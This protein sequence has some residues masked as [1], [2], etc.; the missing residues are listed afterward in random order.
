[1][2]RTFT[3]KNSKISL[4]EL[5]NFTVYPDRFTPNRDG[6]DD[7]VTIS[8]NLTRKADVL[9]YLMGADGK[10]YPVAERPDNAV[11]PGEPGVHTYDYEG[12]V[13]LGAMPPPDGTYRVIAEATDEAGNRVSK[14]AALT[15][16]DG[17]VPRAE[18]VGATA[19]LAP[20]SVPLG[21]TLTVTATVGNIGTVPIRTK[22]PWS[23]SSYTS[24]ENFNTAG[25]YEEPGVFRL[26]VDYE[27]NSA[28]R[29]YPYRWGLGREGDLQLI[30]GQR[31]LMPNQRIVVVGYIRIVEKTPTVNPFF[32]VGLLHEQVRLVNDRIQPTRITIGF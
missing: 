17:G 2:T 5:Q 14:S 4:P 7:R 10:K 29:A 13:D 11:K 26:G 27:G 20:T 6:I 24:L 30:G 31:Y 28:G 12:G 32:W 16:V 19:V 1:M 22:G 25:M 18:I 3:I 8:Y 21:A 23:G 15:V 9:V